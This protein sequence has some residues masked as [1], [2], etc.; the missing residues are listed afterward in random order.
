[1]V[2]PK[3]DWRTKQVALWEE[4]RSLDYMINHKVNHRSMQKHSLSRAGNPE[5]SHCLQMLTVLRED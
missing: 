5:R 3:E 2:E 1:M 4:W